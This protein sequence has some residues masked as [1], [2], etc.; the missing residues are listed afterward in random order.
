MY[1]VKLVHR[2]VLYWPKI[3]FLCLSAISITPDRD[4]QCFPHFFLASGNFEGIM[5]V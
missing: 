2:L 5:T 1:G 4:M 3:G